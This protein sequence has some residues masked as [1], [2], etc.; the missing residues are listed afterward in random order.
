MIHDS[1]SVTGTWSDEAIVDHAIVEPR[2][3]SARV[4]RVKTLILSRHSLSTNPAS[5]MKL[6]C[7]F[8]NARYSTIVPSVLDKFTQE[9]SKQ[10]VNGS[11]SERVS[12]TNNRR[13]ELIECE[14]FR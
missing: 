13:F 8:V 7:F 12:C 9:N 4:D 10:L 2:C 3:A 14:K 11:F 6:G 5:C 1:T